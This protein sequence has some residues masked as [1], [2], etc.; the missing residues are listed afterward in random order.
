MAVVSRA[1]ELDVPSP[2]LKRSF[3]PDVWKRRL[4]STSR[5]RAINASY[6]RDDIASRLAGL[7]VRQGR[8]IV[9]AA[10]SSSGA[11]AVSEALRYFQMALDCYHAAMRRSG[12]CGE[13]R[14][15]W[16]LFA[17]PRGSMDQAITNLRAV[18]AERPNYLGAQRLSCSTKPCCAA[19]TGW[20]EHVI[21]SWR[22]RGT[23]K[24]A[25]CR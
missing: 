9:E 14:P 4:P 6:R 24:P 25:A 18:Y 13:L 17:L 20:W 16:R 23:A 7:Y 10:P 11:E 1:Y 5:F 2:R 22:M 3:K 19:G 15:I 8:T 12:R 21:T